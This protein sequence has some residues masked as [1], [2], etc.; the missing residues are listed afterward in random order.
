[1]TGLRI[2]RNRLRAYWSLDRLFHRK[3]G[4]RALFDYGQGAVALRTERFHSGRVEGRAIAALADRQIGDD[5]PVGCREDNHVV[6][7][8]AGGEEDV[9]LD[10]QCE[11]RASSAFAGEI[12]P[13][14][15]LH[16]RG[17]DYGDGIFVFD[18][19][20]DFALAIGLGLLWRTADVDGAEDGS[21]LVVDHGDVGRG[22]GEI[23]EAMVIAVVQIAMITAKVFESNM[24]MGLEVAKPCPVAVSTTAPCAL[25][26]GMSP[27][28]LKVS[29]E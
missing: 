8:A 22:M 18:V 28:C 12:I 2:Q 6:V 9:V 15:H 11:A 7:L 14:D 27:T 10:I 16:G 1:V 19:D 25:T 5:V 26:S 23:V 29:S 4:G 20:V 13:A 17:I 3:A 21:V 24:T